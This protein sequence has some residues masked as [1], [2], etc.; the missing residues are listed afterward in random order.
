[1]TLE[2]MTQFFGWCA[3][4]NIAM[5]AIAA[6]IVIWQQKWILKIHS[7]MFGVPK[8]D[9]SIVYFKYLAYY[10]IAILVFNLAPYFALRI[11]A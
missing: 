5:L 7:G 6:A 11:I 3:I 10:K 2:Q 8:Q 9:L 4:L 1:M